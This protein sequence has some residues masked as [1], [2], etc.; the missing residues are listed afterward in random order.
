MNSPDASATTLAGRLVI[1]SRRVPVRQPNEA[2]AA[3]VAEAATK[4]T[5]AGPR[6]GDR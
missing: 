4:A 3:A 2:E 1:L 6:L 5:G